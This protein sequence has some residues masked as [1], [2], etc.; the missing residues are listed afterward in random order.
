MCLSVSRSVH[1]PR[2]APEKYSLKKTAVAVLRMQPGALGR[3]ESLPPL[4]LSRVFSRTQPVEIHV[5]N[6]IPD[7]LCLPS[8]KAGRTQR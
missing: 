7:V 1:W 5:F 2:E 6:K 4:H 3:P 8:R